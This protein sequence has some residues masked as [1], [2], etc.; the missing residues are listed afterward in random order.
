[1]KSSRRIVVSAA[2]LVTTLIVSVDSAKAECASYTTRAASPVATLRTFKYQVG[3]DAFLRLWDTPWQQASQ[4][5]GAAHNYFNNCEVPGIGIGF[6]SGSGNMENSEYPNDASVTYWI[7]GGGI[8]L[9]IARAAL[10]AVISPSPDPAPTTTTSTTVAPAAQSQDS[11]T[12][13]ASGSSSATSDTNSVAVVQNEE[14][15]GEVVEDFAELVINQSGRRYVIEVNSSF[16]GEIFT[17]RA[18]ISSQR[19]VVWRVQTDS[20]GYR[21]ILTSRNLFGYSVSLWLNGERIDL[22]T[23]R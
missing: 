6:G 10:Y 19:S 4:I 15:D 12:P 5:I 1:M 18:R 7:Y 8:D 11:T 9:N 2:V 13:T 16:P 23:V 22:V 14:D 17:V 20:S 3:R 21:R